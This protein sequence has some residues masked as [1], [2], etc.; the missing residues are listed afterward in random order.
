MKF[1]R[2]SFI[3]LSEN[4]KLLKSHFLFTASLLLFK[5]TLAHRK[6]DFFFYYLVIIW[7]IEEFFSPCEMIHS[8]V[9]WIKTLECPYCI[10]PKS[11]WPVSFGHVPLGSTAPIV[12]EAEITR[13][14]RRPCLFFLRTASSSFACDG[15][16]SRCECNTSKITFTALQLCN[17]SFC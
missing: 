13:P 9:L 1:Y 2:T 16:L 14:I 5:W 11:V 8:N 3:I 4:Q 17:C 10:S 12:C 15:L 6:S 7:I